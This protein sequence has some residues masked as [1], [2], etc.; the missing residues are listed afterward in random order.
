MARAPRSA[1]G[2]AARRE[3][4]SVA[5]KGRVHTWGAPGEVNGQAK[6]T[7]ASVAAMREAHQAGAGLDDLA[8]RYRVS[9]SNVW[10]IVTG[11]TWR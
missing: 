2:E 9:R 3:K 10:L 11:K 6:L 1:E 4:I 5:H 8:A 7:A